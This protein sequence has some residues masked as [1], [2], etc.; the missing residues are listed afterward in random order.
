MKTYN[1]TM[2]QQL[3]EL[4]NIMQVFLPSRTPDGAVYNKL[5][6]KLVLLDLLEN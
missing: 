3:S 2:Y 1:K 6:I 5:S 4:V